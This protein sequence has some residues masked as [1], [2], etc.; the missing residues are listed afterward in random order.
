MSHLHIVLKLPKKV[1]FKNQQF[2]TYLSFFSKIKIY[3]AKNVLKN[4]LR[5]VVK[6]VKWDFLA[7]FYTQWYFYEF[8]QVAFSPSECQ[9][10]IKVDISKMFV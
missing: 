6:C 1:S 9:A 3:F 4:E 5:N 8:F 7:N 2:F 10:S